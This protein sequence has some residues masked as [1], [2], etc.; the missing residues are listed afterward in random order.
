ME[1][2]YTKAPDKIN[3]GISMIIYAN[4]GVG[5]TTLASTLTPEE[6]LIITTEA[7]LG[8]LLGKGHTLLDI[9][10][11]Q[12]N[13]PDK[14]LEDIIQEIYL[15]LRTS[16]HPFKNVVLDNLS[17]LENS[18]LQDYT[19]RR[20]KH[21]PEIRE[22]GDVS[23]KMKEWVAMFRDLEYQGINVVFMAWELAMDIKNSNGEVITMTV[24]FVG[25]K[26]AIQICGL[27][28]LVGHL[29]VYEKTGVRWVRVGPSSQYLTKCQFQGLEG[30]EEADLPKLLAK[31]NTHEYVAKK[32]VVAQTNDK[33]TK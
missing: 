7:G 18:L 23:Y 9:R 17:E 5:K 19:R 6:T 4:P 2:K 15:H 33:E 31:L 12:E 30:G 29:E 13:N 25:K 1:I 10:K 3:R 11:V 20:K 16:K 8:P 24:P 26:V 28:D 32:A 27:V 14:S 21:T 22:H